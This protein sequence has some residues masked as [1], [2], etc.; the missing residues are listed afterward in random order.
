MSGENSS[1]QVKVLTHPVI[2]YFI[3]E[4]IRQQRSVDHISHDAPYQKSVL[5]LAVYLLSMVAIIG[6]VVFFYVLSPAEYIDL[7]LVNGVVSV[8]V[9]LVLLFAG[10]QLA[11]SDKFFANAYAC[12]AFL[13]LLGNIYLTGFS[14]TSPYLPLI[15]YIP[16]WAFLLCDNKSAVIWCLVTA[17]AFILIYS[18][19]VSG[20]Q[21]PDI[22]P[23]K[24][25]NLAQLV[26]WLGVLTLVGGS[27]FAFQ[28]NYIELSKKLAVERSHY[29]FHAEHD[30][31]TG[32]ANRKLFYNRAKKALDITFEEDLR[33][34][35][36]YIDLDDFKSINDN[37]GHQ[38]GDA[39]IVAKADSL[40]GA[41]RSSD[42]VARLGGDEF[43]I[44][45]HA[46]KPD[47][48]DKVLNKLKAAMEKPIEFEGNT[49]HVG[50]SIGIALAQDDGN[51]VD[52]LIKHAD[53]MMYKVKQAAAA[54]AS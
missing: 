4:G 43:G 49:F 54:K 46:I 11:Q 21:A 47:Q 18:V 15:L 9:F 20:F 48:S 23:E 7:V 10:K 5:I 33:A 22:L 1:A 44:V 50:C 36:I 17:L 27:V 38:A 34:A 26:G 37:Y 39:V 25:D 31:L 28:L 41:V 40:R 32:L 12:A 35:I 3:P 14:W 53:E 45:L 52:A 16:V 29:E 6:T 19:T 13:S 24:F 42:T 51:D 8:L 2:D 30:A